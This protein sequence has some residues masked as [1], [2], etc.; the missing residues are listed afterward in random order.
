MNKENIEYDITVAPQPTDTTCGP[1]CLEALYSYYGVTDFKGP[2][3]D[4]IDY[5]EDGGTLGVNLGID[6]LKRNF[7]VDIYT[8]NLKVFD[9]TWFNLAQKDLELKLRKQQQASKDKK[10]VTASGYYADFIKN[11]GQILFRN[12]NIDFLYQLLKNN[13]PIICGLSSTY[14][15]QCERETNDNL[16]YDDINGMPQGHFV[17]I[18]GI[19]GDKSHVFIADPFDNNPTFGGQKYWVDIQH[20]I[21]SVL[22]GVITYD[23][24]FIVIKK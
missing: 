22:I 13:G 4:Q 5:D 11:N 15:Y 20:F 9:P 19:T 2:L 10:T 1:T 17:V 7:S 24:N 3:I 8:H 16:I 21:N 12:L 23:A 6:A 14:L 18:C